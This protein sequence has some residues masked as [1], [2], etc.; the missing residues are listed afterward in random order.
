MAPRMTPIRAQENH[1]SGI[2]LGCFSPPVMVATFI[3][4]VT[5]AI[6]ALVRYKLTPVT[7]LIAAI[8]LLLATFQLAEFNVCT[9]SGI[10]WEWSRIGYVAI[11]LLP[12]LGIHLIYAIAAPR[13]RPLLLLA[14]ATGAAFMLY[15]LFFTDTLTGHTCMGNYVF[16]QISHDAAWL[17]AFYYYGWLLAGVI[18]S[19]R[20][21]PGVRK[22]SLRKAL[23]GVVAGYAA[24]ILP[25]TAVNLLSPATTR[26]IP[27]IMCGFA[28][29][30]A[31]I[32]ALY[33]LPRAVPH[34]RR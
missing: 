14:N 33:V 15:F 13:R 32:I 3:V 25:T 1:K 31:L 9:G 11:T 12:P 24:F 21:L 4:E 29:I 30:M 23:T 16:F 10:G 22:P 6:Y 34:R 18:L 2:V 20:L 27:S 28:I 26:G 17:Y 7:R 19:W 5:L 8:L